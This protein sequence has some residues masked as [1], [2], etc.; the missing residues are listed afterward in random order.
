MRKAFAILGMLVIVALFG[1]T[2][3]LVFEYVRR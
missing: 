2:A 1:W 3:A